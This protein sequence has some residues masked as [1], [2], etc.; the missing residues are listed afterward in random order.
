[1]KNYILI[2]GFIVLGGVNLF[3]LKSYSQNKAAI[4]L[5]HTEINKIKEE[6]KRLRQT[7]IYNLDVNSRFLDRKFKQLE[8]NTKIDIVDNERNISTAKSEATNAYY[9]ARKVSGRLDDLEEQVSNALTSSDLP[10][11]SFSLAKAFDDLDSRV[12]S[13]ELSNSSFTNSTTLD[14]HEN[15]LKALFEATGLRTSFFQYGF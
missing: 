11:G 4:D 15:A 14:K 10:L 5:V 1:M 2:I 3:L 6:N 8:T 7:V 12:R 13:L 9:A